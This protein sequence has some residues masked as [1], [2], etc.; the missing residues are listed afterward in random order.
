MADKVVRPGPPRDSL[1]PGAVF[2]VDVNV[3]ASPPVNSTSVDEC[4]RTALKRGVGNALRHYLRPL[5]DHDSTGQLELIDLRQRHC[6]VTFFQTDTAELV[7]GTGVPQ[8]MLLQ[9]RAVC[10]VPDAR[11]AYAACDQMKRPVQVSA[12]TTGIVASARRDT[13]ASCP[14]GALADVRAASAAPCRVHGVPGALFSPMGGVRVVFDVEGPTWKDRAWENR[15]RGDIGD[16]FATVL[17]AHAGDVGDRILTVRASVVP[18]GPNGTRLPGI[19]AVLGVS[20]RDGP[21]DLRT[22]LEPRR[23]DIGTALSTKLTDSLCQNQSLWRDLVDLAVNG[24]ACP[25][26]RV[27]LRR[28]EELSEEVSSEVPQPTRMVQLRLGVKGLD[29]A[30][31]RRRPLMWQAFGKTVVRHVMANISAPPPQVFAE[32]GARSADVTVVWGF[33]GPDAE[34]AAEALKG[35]VGRSAGSIRV[36]VRGGLNAF[37]RQDDDHLR[38]HVGPGVISVALIGSVE[39]QHAGLWPLEG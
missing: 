5:V 3:S 36:A 18:R 28:I 11:A 6:S 35:A 16:L 34:T 7:R 14:Q 13:T 17:R 39:V 9:A 4:Q 27:V 23:G 15:T 38:V 2:V 37:V 1:L 32:G 24:S 10:R 12:L 29:Y 33:S 31:V 20:G 26:V 22:V 8:S 25:K 30:A 21:S 19:V